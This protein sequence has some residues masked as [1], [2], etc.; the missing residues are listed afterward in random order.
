ML[1]TFNAQVEKGAITEESFHTIVP[2]DFGASFQ[3]LQPRD[4]TRELTGCESFHTVPVNDSFAYSL[5]GGDTSFKKLPTKDSFAE[6]ARRGLKP[7]PKDKSKSRS[8]TADS[9]PGSSSKLDFPNHC[10]PQASCSLPPV[11]ELYPTPSR[12]HA[13]LAAQHRQ[14]ALSVEA[15]PPRAGPLMQGVQTAR[16]PLRPVPGVRQQTPMPTRRGAC[17]AQPPQ[18]MLCGSSRPLGH[19]QPWWVPQTCGEWAVA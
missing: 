15:L 10:L 1:A 14:R 13:G 5:V 19:D 4:W 9:P 17:A 7:S 8:K 3:T 18:A 12:A 16:G 11:P 6:A 2:D